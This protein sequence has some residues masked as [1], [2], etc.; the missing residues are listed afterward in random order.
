MEVLRRSGRTSRDA[1]PTHARTIRVAARGNP[2]M[3]SS[4]SARLRGSRATIHAG[5]AKSRPCSPCWPATIREGSQHISRAGSAWAA[6]AGV[7]R[8]RRGTRCED[9]TAFQDGET[10]P[11]NTSDRPNATWCH[12]PRAR[13]EV[14]VTLEWSA[15]ATDGRG[16]ANQH[17]ACEHQRCRFGGWRGAASCV[18]FICPVAVCR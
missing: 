18:H 15:G 4:C 16:E 11:R 9:A 12:D 3:A 13:G 7:P 10:A 2:T 8:G 6:S 17:D 14:A 1:A 5:G